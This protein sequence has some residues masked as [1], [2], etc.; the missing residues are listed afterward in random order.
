MLVAGGEGQSSTLRSCELYDPA[1]G[2]W[3]ETGALHK[4]RE[5]HR[6]TLL[7]DGR[8]LV[9]GGLVDL[10]RTGFSHVA[11][12]YNVARGVWE[13]GDRPLF[14]TREHAQNLLPDGSV[15]V[16]GGASDHRTYITRE[17]QLGRPAAAE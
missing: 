15:L 5:D 9:A 8:V 14:V 10:L 12:I 16:S 3:T 13:W 17:A 4:Y 11:E 2:E 6:A 1:T 7:P